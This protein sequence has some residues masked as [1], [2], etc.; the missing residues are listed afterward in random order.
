MKT[1]QLAIVGLTL[2]AFNISAAMKPAENFRFAGD[3]GFANF[4][5]AVVT[6]DLS[7]LKRSIRSK[8][9]DIAASPK[10]VLRKLISDEGMKCNDTNLID[11]SKQR[12]AQDIHAF[13]TQQN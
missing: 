11:F 1:K 6:D 5:Q 7:L 2:L 13:L 9:G 12:E 3:L 8:V 10:E 4:C